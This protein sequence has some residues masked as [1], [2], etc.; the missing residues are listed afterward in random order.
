[1][2]IGSYYIVNINGYWWL[3]YHRLLVVI[4]LV[5]IGNYF[6]VSHFNYFIGYFKLF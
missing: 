6:I 4:L 3:N 5:A 1:M 2:V